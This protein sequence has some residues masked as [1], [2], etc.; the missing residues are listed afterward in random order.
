MS[1]PVAAWHLGQLHA[2]EQALVLVIAFGPFVV[3]GI[4][5]GVLRRRDLDR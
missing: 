1:L 2:Y 4:V 5:V 3:L